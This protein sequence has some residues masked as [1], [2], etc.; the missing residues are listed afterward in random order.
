MQ[1]RGREENDLSIRSGRCQTCDRQGLF[2]IPRETKGTE[3]L[4][5][6]RYS[7]LKI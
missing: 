5:N 3:G 1:P 7:R 4:I 6:I 2:G